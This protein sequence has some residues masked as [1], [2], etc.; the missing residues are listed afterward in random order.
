MNTIFTF[1]PSDSHSSK[2]IAESLTSQKDFNT[3]LR[4][5]IGKSITVELK[6]TEKLSEKERM[7]GFYHRVILGVAMQVFTNEGWD[8]M[9]K[10][11][12]DYFMKAECGKGIM[13]NPI[14]EAEEVY[15][16][17]KARMNKDRLRKFIMD[18]ITFLEIEKGAKV[19]DSSEYMMELRT[20]F[21]GFKSVK[22]KKG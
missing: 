22:K 3:F 10:V 13:Y 19:P 9:D 15:L 12:A 1:Y 6:L 20:G 16:L 5:N 7:Y 18:C 11:K 17:D 14:T 4:G 21:S 2:E 8:G